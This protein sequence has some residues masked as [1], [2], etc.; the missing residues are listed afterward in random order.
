MVG[1]SVGYESQASL[2]V[3]NNNHAGNKRSGSCNMAPK[4]GRYP[5]GGMEVENAFFFGSAKTESTSIMESILWNAPLTWK[6]MAQR[7]LFLPSFFIALSL[8]NQ[9]LS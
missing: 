7:R 4:R 6:R 2:K 1:A 9:Y 8:S 3:I 5:R